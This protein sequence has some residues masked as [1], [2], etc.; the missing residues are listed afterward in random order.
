MSLKC[1]R[2]YGNKW[3]FSN[4]ENYIVIQKVIPR[5]NDLDDLGS[6]KNYQDY[7]AV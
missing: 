7:G 1:H 2:D 5:M 6:L 3:S 4:I